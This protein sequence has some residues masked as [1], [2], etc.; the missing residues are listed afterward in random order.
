MLVELERRGYRMGR[1]ETAMLG[2][3]NLMRAEALW[4]RAVRARGTDG[5]RELLEQSRVHLL[6]ALNFYEEVPTYAGVPSNRA[7]AASRLD[8][9]EARLGLGRKPPEEDPGFLDELLGAA[10]GKIIEEIQEGDGDG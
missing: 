4:S 9:V 6:Q 8:Q 7:K 1:R 3:G 10:A 2:D 5:E